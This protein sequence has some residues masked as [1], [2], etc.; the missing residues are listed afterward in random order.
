GR[1]DVRLQL[2]AQDVAVEGERP[3]NVPDVQVQVADAEALGHEAGR[4]LAGD[5]AQ[6]ALEVERSGAAV[7]AQAGRP[8]LAVAIPGQLYA[9]TVDVGQVDRLV[10]AVVRRALDPGTG[11][12]QPDCDA[13]QLL[14]RREQQRVVVEAGVASGG[15]RVGI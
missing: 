13:G 2:E 5:R 14:A 3:L 4:L 15:P 12:R 1:A 7:V 10:R 8:P 9:V 6:E 11:L